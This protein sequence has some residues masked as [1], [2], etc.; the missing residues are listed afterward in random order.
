MTGR[1]SPRVISCGISCDGA[2]RLSE[3]PDSPG[4]AAP[5]P[6]LR[7]GGVPG[8]GR[9]IVGKGGRKKPQNKGPERC[10]AV[11]EKFFA[12]ASKKGVAGRFESP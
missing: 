11:T 5:I 12:P 1:E 9:K 2:F 8:S 4:R 3:S 10:F 7:A 6:P